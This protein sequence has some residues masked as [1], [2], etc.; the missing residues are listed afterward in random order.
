M[1]NENVKVVGAL[2]AA[3]GAGFALKTLLS[4]PKK[5]KY[6]LHYFDG[7]GVAE[8]SRYL[9]AVAGQKYEDHRYPLTFNEE[10]K[11]MTR[12]EWDAD[13]NAG[14]WE[15]HN[16]LPCLEVDGM[17]IN[18]SQAIARFLA[19]R[20]DL[21]GAND[22]EGARIDAVMEDIADMKKTYFKAKNQKDPANKTADME[23]FFSSDLP[24][25]FAKVEKLCK[26]NGS[27]FVVGASISLGDIALFE[28]Q[29]FWDDLESFNAASK[30]CSG[31]KTLCANVAN[32]P[33]IAKWIAERPNTRF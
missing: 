27:G 10:T 25:F 24:K 12:K 7:R 33:G 28:L 3:F 31:F 13:K 17:K 15:P 21:F 8:T 2:A 1:D 9:F 29:T 22:V 32:N 4:G 14:M 5:S 30:G 26:L 18:Q 19:K 16:T 11:Q 6:T 23:S 20:L